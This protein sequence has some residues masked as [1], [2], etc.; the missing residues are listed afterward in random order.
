MQRESIGFQ[1]NV[2]ISEFKK[3]NARI[4]EGTLNTFFSTQYVLIS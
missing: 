4:N 3:F 1:T 2:H